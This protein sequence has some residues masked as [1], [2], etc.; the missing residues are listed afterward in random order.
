MLLKRL[1]FTALG[2][3]VFTHL[4]FTLLLHSN[5]G[6]LDIHDFPDSGDQAL[7]FKAVIRPA[8]RKVFKFNDTFQHF[9]SVSEKPVSGFIEAREHSSN[10]EKLVDAFGVIS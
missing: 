6:V 9:S 1:L 10:N 2:F 4:S 8:S 3:P 7:C 5:K